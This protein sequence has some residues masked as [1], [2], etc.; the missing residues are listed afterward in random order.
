MVKIESPLTIIFKLDK[1]VTGSI[2]AY[3]DESKNVEI[4]HIEDRKS[5]V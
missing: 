1:G 2:I 3:D 5:V 4:G